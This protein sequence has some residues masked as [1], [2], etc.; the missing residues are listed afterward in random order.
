MHHSYNK[1]RTTPNWEHFDGYKT[2]DTFNMYAVGN[3]RTE[4]ELPFASQEGKNAGMRY[5]EMLGERHGLSG[6]EG[7]LHPETVDLD[8]VLDPSNVGDM[9]VEEIKDKYNLGL[10]ARIG[11][12]VEAFIDSSNGH[13]RPV[14]GRVEPEFSKEWERNLE[15]RGET[16][17][18]NGLRRANLPA[19]NTVMFDYP[20]G[21]EWPE[22]NAHRF[23]IKLWDGIKELGSMASDGLE[24]DMKLLKSD[25]VGLRSW[26]WSVLMEDSVSD[27]LKEMTPE[28]V[29]ERAG[30][31]RKG[32]VVDE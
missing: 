12:S 21:P 26:L 16:E 1:P 7:R 6:D 9:T 5:S 20:N 18:A 28:S 32:G 25:P 2:M 8:N 22:R 4:E 14:V 17:L 30:P 10:H 27:K 29:P 15:S 11:R 23:G 13:V 24:Y 31:S 19:G 3:W